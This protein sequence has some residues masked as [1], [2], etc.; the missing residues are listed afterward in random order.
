[1]VG[2]RSQILGTSVRRQLAYNAR[3]VGVISLSDG[4]NIIAAV[5]PVSV[6]IR[7]SVHIRVQY[8]FSRSQM[9]TEVFDIRFP[10]YTVT[11][12]YST[13]MRRLTKGIRSEKCVVGRFRLCANVIDCTY[14]SLHPRL[15]GI[16]YCS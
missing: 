15:Y 14:T 13:D 7:I 4:V 9:I 12:C 16:A 11:Q 2:V 1:M 8:F 6:K 5:F 10:F 3:G